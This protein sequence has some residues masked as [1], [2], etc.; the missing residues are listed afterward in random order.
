MKI[1]WFCFFIITISLFAC[2][3]KKPINNNS[4]YS[5]QITQ[6]FNQVKKYPDSINLRVELINVL[7]SCNYLKEALTE[8]D[9]LIKNDSLNFA[10]WNAK[11]H[12][13]EKVTDTLGA[14]TS[15]KRAIR[16]YAEPN[17]MLS[18]A[19]LFAE[20]KNDT[21]LALCKN[22]D[23]LGVNKKYS[24][25]CRFIE[26]I[27][28]ARK[29]LHNQAIA[30]FDECINNRYAYVEAYLEKGFIYYDAKN[31]TEALA[32]FKLASTVSIANAD[33][34]YWQAKCFEAMNNKTEAITNYEKSLTLDKNLKEAGEAIER[35]RK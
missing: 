35:L 25:D 28:F 20:T 14:I 24:A 9:Y 5:A 7:D 33:T 11:A 8:M 30:L 6:L 10:F 29:G 3:D 15:Y 17:S 19:N 16:I 26:G 2:G 4:T 13:Q 32:V 31:Y 21:A 27:Y 23:A 34:Y 18:L 1:K 22:V 12:L